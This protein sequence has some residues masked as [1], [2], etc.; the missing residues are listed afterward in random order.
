MNNKTML[1]SRTAGNSNSQNALRF[2]P[3]LGRYTSKPRVE[4]Y[5]QYLVDNRN[6]IDHAAAKFK[7]QPLDWTPVEQLEQEGYFPEG[8]YWRTDMFPNVSDK[9]QGLTGFYMPSLGMLHVDT[10]KDSNGNTLLPRSIVAHEVGH[11]NTAAR[12]AGGWRSRIPGLR[13]KN[14]ATV[15]NRLY[16]RRFEEPF[17]PYVDPSYSI[18]TLTNGVDR[19]S[20]PDILR[21]EVDAWDAASG[22][23]DPAIRDAALGTYRANVADTWRNN[24]LKQLMNYPSDTPTSYFNSILE[25]SRTR[26]VPVAGTKFRDPSKNTNEYDFVVGTGTYADHPDVAEFWRTNSFESARSA[27]N[28]MNKK[29]QEIMGKSPRPSFYDTP[30]R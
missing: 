4:S 19:A 5:L 3:R 15:F 10:R 26:K 27:L 23:Y 16:N 9:F 17:K 18:D 1:G 30:T 12:K 29:E 22:K 25:N 11:V 7:N 8:P 6:E 14:P 13:W 24:A 28:E 20:M 2:S 21:S